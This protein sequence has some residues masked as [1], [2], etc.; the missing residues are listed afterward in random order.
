MPAQSEALSFYFCKDP[1][2]TTC[3]RTRPALMASPGQVTLD[4]VYKLTLFSR[5]ILF[6][7]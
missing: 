4:S 3:T 7:L 1:L 5:Q 2:Q 6:K